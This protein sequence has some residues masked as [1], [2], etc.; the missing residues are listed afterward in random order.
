MRRGQELPLSKAPS[1][2]PFDAAWLAKGWSLSLLDHLGHQ[3]K[4]TRGIASALKIMGLV[5]LDNKKQTN[6]K[7]P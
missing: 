2:L 4:S 3:D 6:K 1:Q 5:K 7:T